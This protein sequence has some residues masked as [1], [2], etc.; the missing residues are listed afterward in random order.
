MPDF[1]SVQILILSSIDWD[2]AWQRHQIFASQL[3]AAGH[4]IFFVENL[5]ER[6]F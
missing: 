5:R 3:A 6:Y 4:D 1:D 2:A